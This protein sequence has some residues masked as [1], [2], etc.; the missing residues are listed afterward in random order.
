MNE[1]K[2]RKTKEEE[3]FDA[4]RADPDPVVFLANEVLL[5]SDVVNFNQP[6]FVKLRDALAAYFRSRGLEWGGSREINP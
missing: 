5:L 1:D 6:P 4:I 3:I 2:Y